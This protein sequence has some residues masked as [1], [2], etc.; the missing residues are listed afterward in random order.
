[1]AAES[2]GHG[3]G[4]LVRSLPAWPQ[5]AAAMAP[6]G[7]SGHYPHGR[8]STPRQARDRQARDKQ[9]AMA[10]LKARRSSSCLSFSFS[11]QPAVSSISFGSAL[12]RAVPSHLF[13]LNGA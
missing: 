4:W 5:K 8:P 10:S 13:A 9:A 6:G 11:E 12:L 7:W 1:M 3:T 2:G